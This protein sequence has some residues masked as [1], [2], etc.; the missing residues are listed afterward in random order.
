MNQNY[1]VIGLV[2]GAVA[3]V[4]LMIWS[5]FRQRRT[6]SLASR[7]GPEYDHT[8]AALGKRAPAEKELAARAARVEKLSIHPLTAPERERFLELWQTTQTHFVDSPL[9]AVV[10]ADGLVAEVM[11]TRGYPVS[12][13][14]QR[15]ADVSV[16]H[17]LVVEHY[18]T[19]HD[20][21]L[22]HERRQANTED[23]RQA[24]VHFKALFSELLEE[25]LV[26]AEVKE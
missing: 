7:F 6:R 12:D 11:R 15:A 3:V 18:R 8:V 1:L 9:T 20:I 5:L 16:D 17:P 25:R 2:V 19:A 22:R 4:A 24:F 10:E 26:Y 13:F 21:A 23:L 14:E